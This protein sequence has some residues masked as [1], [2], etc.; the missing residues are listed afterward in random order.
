MWS[1]TTFNIFS[2][3]MSL[4]W[5]HHCSS[6]G[7]LLSYTCSVCWVGAYYLWLGYVALIS[8]PSSSA[9]SMPLTSVQSFLATSISSS[10]M[11]VSS[12]STSPPGTGSHSFF[13]TSTVE[14]APF[15]VFTSQASSW[16]WVAALPL[17]WISRY[18][19]MQSISRI[20]CTYKKLL[21]F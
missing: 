1:Y 12:L 20:P 8:P 14:S 5:F 4:D 13:S 9:L 17:S 15:V 21:S 18:H 11:L 2:E 6:R 3:H 7:G 16:S 10:G 19:Q